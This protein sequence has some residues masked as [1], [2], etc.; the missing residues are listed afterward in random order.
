M[1]ALAEKYPQAKKIRVVQDNLNTHN[2]SS[3][4]EHLL[5]EQAF[6][7][8]HRFEFHYTPKAASW[9]NMIEIEFSA[10]SKQCFN[11][12][13]AT[14]EELQKQVLTLVKERER[15]EIKIN[16]QFSVETTREK[17]NRHYEKV[18]SDNKKYQKT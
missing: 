11:R 13:I 5:A 1:Q 2:A 3:F 17:L 7:L 4:Y 16:W 14:Q 15:Q 10:L 18:N 12:R 9:L 8:A 6:A